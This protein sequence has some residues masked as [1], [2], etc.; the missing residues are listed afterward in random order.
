MVIWFASARLACMGTARSRFRD[1]VVRHLARHA[2]AWTW[3]ALCVPQV[4][5]AR[6]SVVACATA[7][8]W[9][10]GAERRSTDRREPLQRPMMI[11]AET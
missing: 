3:H 5:A 10:H 1:H 2:G 8:G 9:A 7:C 4:V 11:G 6:G